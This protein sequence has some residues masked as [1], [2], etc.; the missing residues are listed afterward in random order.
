MSLTLRNSRD[1]GAL[2]RDRRRAQGLSQQALANAI[3]SSRW[4]VNEVEQGKPRAELG[5][6]LKA[7]ARLGVAL[8]ASENEPANA[9]DLGSIVNRSRRPS[10]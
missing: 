3:G 9:S 10:K 6:V 5:L 2:I 4:W 8:V 7:L 1:I